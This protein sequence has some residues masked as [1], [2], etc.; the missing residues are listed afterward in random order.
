VSDA[1]LLGTTIEQVEWRPMC[2]RIDCLCM[3]PDITGPCEEHKDMGNPRCGECGWPPGRHTPEARDV[4]DTYR[5]GYEHGQGLAALMT[6]RAARAFL[7][8][9]ERSA[10]AQLLVLRSTQAMAAG[11]QYA[12]VHGATGTEIPDA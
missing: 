2:D 9:V 11:L 7:G 6:D 4:A 12:L 10:Q 5:I 3:E 8:K 1:E